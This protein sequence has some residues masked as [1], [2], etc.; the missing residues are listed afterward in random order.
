[1]TEELLVDISRLSNEN[2]HPPTVKQYREQGKYS[3]ATYYRR[4]GSWQSALEAA[5]YEAREPSTE[6]SEQSLLSEL[7]RLAEEHNQRPTA[8]LMNEFGNYWASTYRRHF[9]TWAN[10]L[11]EAGFE[12]E[13]YHEAP[14]SES[15]LL[16][17][18]AELSQK[19]G[20]RPTTDDMAKEGKYGVQTYYRRF[21]SWENAL[22][23]AGLETP[24]VSRKEL[25]TH[26]QE[27][28]SELGHI[29]TMREM[30]SQ[31]EH[32]PNTYANRFESWSKALD[33][34]FDD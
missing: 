27:L 33:I 10:A 1:M 29:P 19:L 14:V 17:E 6:V 4:F 13:G 24:G 34:A 30:N 3:L 18:L 32:S 7:H 11:R 28:A 16:E 23:A 8:V 5:G 20:H 22:E 21:G 25:I 15:H 26:L 2:E 12:T 31:G 9:G